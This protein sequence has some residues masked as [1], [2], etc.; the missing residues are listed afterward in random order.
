VRLLTESGKSYEVNSTCFDLYFA[1][2]F[3]L[4]LGQVSSGMAAS[5]A[6]YLTAIQ[7]NEVA[8]ETRSTETNATGGVSSSGAKPATKGG[9]GKKSDAS[10]AKTQEHVLD[11]RRTGSVHFMG[12]I[13]KK[14][15][16]TPDYEIGT[17]RNKNAESRAQRNTQYQQQT[18]EDGFDEEQED[19]EDIYNEG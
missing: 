16:I 7:L 6:Q 3:L 10:T 12:N 1:L 18:N 15:V 2:I 5:F 19:A 13:T 14:L 9:S 8:P 4:R 11:P 17:K